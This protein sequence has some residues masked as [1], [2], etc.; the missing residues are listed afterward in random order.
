MWRYVC[1]CARDYDVTGMSGMSNDVTGM[2]GMSNDVREECLEYHMPSEKNVTL[3][4]WRVGVSIK[5]K[6]AQT[7]PVSCYENTDF[8]QLHR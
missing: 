6:P 3:Q 5:L 8:R 1:S 2:S 4:L 7:K